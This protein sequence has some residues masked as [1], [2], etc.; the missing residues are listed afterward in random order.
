MSGRI[1]LLKKIPSPKYLKAYKS[2]LST[3]PNGRIRRLWNVLVNPG[4]G[5]PLAGL[6][7]LS[8]RDIF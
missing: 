2:K 1:G 3:Y 5:S 8:K 4:S 7:V 6:K